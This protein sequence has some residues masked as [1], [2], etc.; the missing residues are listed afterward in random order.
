MST[1]LRNWRSRY[2]RGTWEIKESRQQAITWL[3]ITKIWITLIKSASVQLN[4]IE[5]G[6]N[7]YQ[8]QAATT[9]MISHQFLKT[10]LC[11]LHQPGTPHKSSAINVVDLKSAWQATVVLIAIASSKASASI[12][13]RCQSAK[14]HP[15]SG[16]KIGI[17]LPA[18][19][20]RARTKTSDSN[21]NIEQIMVII[22]SLAAKSLRIISYM[23]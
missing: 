8:P 23:A 16:S 4:A 22:K 21:I 2:T 15:Q 9:C 18:S 10:Q 6:S 13:L 3:Q 12:W 19:Q 17:P 14:L 20:I 1:I 5:M 11:N 7:S